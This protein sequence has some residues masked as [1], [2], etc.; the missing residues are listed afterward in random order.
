M[1]VYLEPDLTL[2][3]YNQLKVHNTQP[4][5]WPNTGCVFPAPQTRCSMMHKHLWE[6]LANWLGDQDTVNAMAIVQGLPKNVNVFCFPQA[7]P[8]AIWLQQAWFYVTLLH[9]LHW[10]RTVSHCLHLSCTST[11]PKVPE[12]LERG[13]GQ[14]KLLDDLVDLFLSCFVFLSFPFPLPPWANSQLTCS[15]ELMQGDSPLKHRSKWVCP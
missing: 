11:I 1:V 3:T 12:C 13:Q 15:T 7:A 14:S 2:H 10:N 5:I 8:T 4:S 6:F 9:H